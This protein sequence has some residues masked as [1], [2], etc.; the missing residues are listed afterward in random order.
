AFLKAWSDACRWRGKSTVL[1]PQGSY[2]LNEVIFSGPCNSW[3]NF[4]IEGR[5]KAPSDIYSFK[6]DSW[7]S[8]RYVNN[9]YVGGGGTLDGQGAVAWAKND[10]QKNRNC[11][12]L[13][14][15]MTFQFI[16]N[17]YIHHMRSINSKQN[18]FTLYGCKNMVLTKLK[19]IAP[20]NSPNTDG[21][22]I[23]LSMGITIT[24]V[25]IG[26]GDDCIAMLY[27]T[28]GVRISD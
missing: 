27:G 19:L 21:I 13:P 14:G 15:T 24:S 16:T 8:F 20:F 12:V 5:L 10:C 6:T 1:I 4:Q 18:H 22:K 9:L 28:K 23:A 26:T 17:G 3:M 25:S 2:M 7:I 11:R